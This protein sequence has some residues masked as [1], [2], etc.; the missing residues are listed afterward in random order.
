ERYFLSV[1]DD[2]ELAQTRARL[3]SAYESAGQHGLAL[4]VGEATEAFF[5][6]KEDRLSLAEILGVLSS[7]HRRLG[8]Y[9]KAQECIREAQKCDPDGEVLSPGIIA[10]SLGELHLLGGSP[11]EVARKNFQKAL[12]HAKDG[13]DRFGELKA[14]LNLAR[15]SLH[16]GKNEAV[17]KACRGLLADLTDFDA[18]RARVHCL[19]G[20]ARF[21]GKDLDGARTEFEAAIAAA[22][23]VSEE[24]RIPAA[25][26]GLARICSDREEW[27]GALD[28]LETAFRYLGCGSHER[29]PLS[30]IEQRSH[31]GELFDFALEV[32]FRQGDP[33]RTLEII[34]RTRAGVIVEGLGG[35]EALVAQSLP[36]ALRAEL[37][38]ARA[39]LA[40]AQRQLQAAVTAGNLPAARRAVKQVH[41]EQDAYRLALEPTQRG[42]PAA[43]LSGKTP[44][45][46]LAALQSDLAKDQAFVHYALAGERLRALVVTKKAATRH[47][48]GP[49]E[50]AL[51]AAKA[52][53]DELESGRDPKTAGE[54]RALLIARL[55]L[56]AAARRIV[57][58]PAGP[59]AC[60]PF[61]IIEP[62]RSF[63]FAPS[64]TAWSMLKRAAV[65]PGDGVLAMGDPAYAV[66][67]APPAAG[68][69]R[70]TVQLT[71]LPGTRREVLSATG[72]GDVR[73]L[74]KDATEQRLLTELSAGKRWHS[75]HFACHGFYDRRRPAWSALA[76]SP[77]DVEDGFLTVVE[78]F[79]LR[80]PSDLVVLSACETGLVGAEL[81]DEVVG[82]AAGFV[83][84]G[85]AGVVSTL[86]A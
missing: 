19:A 76:L 84:A 72:P 57:I 75:V 12:L 32:A 39:R 10:D 18:Y 55:G 27:A 64:A 71:S 7:I 70:G 51:A 49:R 42:T 69:Y 45:R 59:L 47:D 41:R 44:V 13:D 81:P 21:R 37:D 67:A 29:D 58:S 3:A 35:R 36:A 62:D 8:H 83:Q 34:E 6:E 2:D 65:D 56:P 82:L 78:I 33:A 86:W 17:L 26:L 5:R 15:V 4:A 60:L 1:G 28:H 31:Y 74:G 20:R 85:A 9:R 43:V 30:T 79:G 11:P 16:E 40:I 50:L 73:L 25:H 54:I 14:R 22:G 38:D 63:S 61:G 66:G 48:L 53:R 23:R 68:A 77:G 24:G 80:V 46:S 52:L